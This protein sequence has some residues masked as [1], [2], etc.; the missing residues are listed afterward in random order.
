MRTHAAFTEN[1]NVI[2][3]RSSRSCQSPTR[4]SRLRPGPSAP[5]E[6]ALGVAVAIKSPDSGIA[7]SPVSTTIQGSQGARHGQL[8]SLAGRVCVATGLRSEQDTH[9]ANQVRRAS[10]R[11]GRACGPA[12]HRPARGDCK[13]RRLR[14]DGDGVRRLR[15]SGGSAGCRAASAC[16][17]LGP[18]SRAVE[19]E[20]TIVV[21]A[22]IA[23]TQSAESTD[24]PLADRGSRRSD[25][26]G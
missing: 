18:R 4:S 13:P 5:V 1:I 21:A 22:S 7:E 15:K 2:P 11:N 6:S 9:T 17:P 19:G 16:P 3:S 8:I 23:A 26:D 14:R 12:G 10:R 25:Q 20:A 24:R